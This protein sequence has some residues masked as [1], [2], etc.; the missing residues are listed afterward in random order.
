MINPK[1]VSEKGSTVGQEGCLSFPDIGVNVARPDFITVE[2]L[3]VNGER[4]K[5]SFSGAEAI[6]IHHEVDHLLGR[7]FLSRVNRN[8]RRTAMRALRR[9]K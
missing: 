4:I 7:T 9:S 2:Y 3:D 1:I 8:T 5:K 6:C